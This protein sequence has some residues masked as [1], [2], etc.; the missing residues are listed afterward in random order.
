V[1]LKLVALIVPLGLDSFAVAAALG[2]SGVKGR[3]ALRVS[4]LFGAFEATMPLIGFA[5]GY[6]I[7]H[8]IGAAGDYFAAAVLLAL[9][10]TMLRSRPDEHEPTDPLAYVRGV[11]GLL[12][13]L[14]VSI[15]ELGIG[16]TLGLLRGPVLLVAALVGV[17]AVIFS[18]L[19]LRL[20]ARAG[21]HVRE[22]AER[23]AGV[24]LIALAF[25]VLLERLLA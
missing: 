10:V 20:G 23:L 18:Q 12:L 5:V 7:G 25:S 16:F 9:G 11:R 1:T 13:G 3:P 22:G 8:A 4:A 24:V 19:G 6:P 17:Q 14:S 21:E 2:M 15:D